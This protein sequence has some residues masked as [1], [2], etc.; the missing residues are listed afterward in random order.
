[1]AGSRSIVLVHGA[2]HGPWA[3][4]KVEGPLR[5]RGFDVHTV[6]NPSSGPDPSALADSYGDVEHLR[7][8][9][10]GI[11]NEV[12]LVAHSYGG[13]PVTQAAVGTDN[14]A[15][16]LYVTS[17][18]LDEGESLL[19]VVGGVEPDWWIKDGERS[20]TVTRAEEIFFNDC[21]PEDAEF[22][23]SRLE[24]QSLPSFQQPVREVAWRGGVQ[25]TYVICDNDNAIPVFAQEHLSQRA[26]DV[27]R[28]PASHSPFLSM[29]D[30]VIEIIAELA[31]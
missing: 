27:R 13:I 21:S 24:P 8:I 31:G 25:S 12:L 26:G 23:A 14:V 22:A 3:W 4:S 11:D 10:A 7:G 16:L 6:A 20:T 18:M 9:L 1:M 30:K 19:S 28:L 15:H 29:P 17:F 5:E 2:W